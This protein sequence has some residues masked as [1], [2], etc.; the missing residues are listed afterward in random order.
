MTELDLIDKSLRS[1]SPEIGQLTKLAFLNLS[2]N[3]LKT[4]PP[5]I[6]RKE[7]KAILQ[8]L[9]QLAREGSN[10]LYEAKL[11]IVGEGDAGKTT[12]AHKIQAPTYELPDY[13]SS[14][15][16]IEIVPWHFPHTEA[17]DFQVNIWDFGGQ[18]IY[19]ATHQFF[20]TKRSLYTLVVDSRK[21]HLDLY[22]WL[23]VVELLSHNSPLVILQ[24]EKDDRVVK[25]DLPKL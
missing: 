22:Y 6:I 16:G 5:E 8:Y 13:Q 1:L 14:T 25:I 19:H 15:E 10:H 3:P 21:N 9:Q 12:L 18:E 20:L 4:P 24:N 23:N 17:R 2:G 11:L 7:T